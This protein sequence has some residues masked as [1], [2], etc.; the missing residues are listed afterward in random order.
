MTTIGSSLEI[1]AG[2]V[3]GRTAIV[4]RGVRLTYRELDDQVNRVAHEL[5][6]R[7][8][9]KGDRIAFVGKNCAAFVYVLYAAAKIGALFVPVNPRSAP[10]EVAHLLDDS[11]AVL[12]IAEADSVSLLSKAADAAR[13]R[14]A[15]LSAGQ[16]L[17]LEDLLS[18]AASRPTTR[19][20]AEVFESDDAMILY[21]SGTTGFAK[22]VVM[23]H[24]RLIWTALT[25]S[26][27]TAGMRD[28]ASVVHVAPLYHSGQTTM[29]LLPGTLVGAKHVMVQAFDP[30]AVLD[31]MEKERTTAFF[32]PPTMYQFLMQA[33]LARPRDL[34]AW[35][36][37]VYGAAPM[38]ETLAA[39]L[40]REFASVRIYSCYGQT[41]AGP[42]GLYS[43][44]EEVRARPD[45][46]GYRAFPNTLVRIV[47]EA[48]HDISAGEIGEILL[49]GETIMKGYWNDPDATAKTLVDG[50]VHTGD[51]ARLDADG[52]ITIVD[53]LK[54]MIISGG[55][56][57]YSVE[58]ENAIAAHPG[59]AD[60]A[61]LARAHD[62]YGETVV[63]VVSLKDGAE[64]TLDEL[65]AHCAPLIA[66]YKLPRELIVAPIARNPSGK[67]LKHI[68]RRELGLTDHV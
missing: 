36:M 54:D 22:G 33:Y 5:V 2:R 55:R 35:E 45:V 37:G 49:K 60:N 40:Q 13:A 4:D 66:D 48:G 53:R 46:T 25:V 19:P 63:A 41:E 6:A 64:V 65:R 50:W 7:G 52:G 11:G 14:P 51:L 17:G 44:P 34:S 39:A 9:A 68:M 10:P 20:E 42:G 47:D 26:I 18:A 15:L 21:T 56:N 31:I 38:S 23:D 62:E 1:T 12:A 59:I 8:I 43:S 29:M 27:M 32:G 16:A 57:I 28:G 67:I 30:D 61:V 24:H 3:P 58:V